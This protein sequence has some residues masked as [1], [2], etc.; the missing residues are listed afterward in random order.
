[1]PIGLAFTELLEYTDWE[2]GQWRERLRHGPAEVLDTSTGPNGDG[3][4]AKVGEVVRHIFSAELRYVE[5]LTGRPITDTSAIPADDAVALF[6][7]GD[8]S[9]QELRVYIGTVPDGDWDT[10]NEM[11]LG[12]YYLAASTKKVISHVLLH[13]IR[14]WAQIATILRLSGVKAEPNDFL[15]CPVL[16]GEFRNTSA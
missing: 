9:R 14:H 16:G 15:F 13:E 10:V 4:F 3:R 11:T 2:R 5:R 8:R 1:M 12:T 6:Q 7:L